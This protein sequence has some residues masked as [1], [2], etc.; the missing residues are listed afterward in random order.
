VSIFIICGVT[1]IIDAVVGLLNSALYAFENM[2]YDAIGQ[3]VRGSLLVAICLP[4]ICCKTPFIHILWISAGISSLKVLICWYGLRKKTRPLPDQRKNLSIAMSFSIFKD[5]FAFA[6]LSIVSV[7]YTNLIILLLRF[8]LKDDTS[9]GYFA[10]AQRIYLFAL[11]IPAMFYQAIYPVLSRKFVEVPDSFADIFEKLYRYLLAIAF[12]VAVGMAILAPF[13]IHLI[14]GPRFAPSVP[15]LRI[16]SLGLLNGPGFVMGAALSAMNKQGLNAVIFGITVIFLGAFSYFTIPTLGIEGAC[17]AMVVSN[18]VGLL[19]Y[20]ILLFKFLETPYP[21]KWLLK[22]SVATVAMGLCVIGTSY[23]VPGRIVS[24]SGSIIS[25]GAV[26]LA[27]LVIVRSFSPRDAYLVSS[28]LPISA[29][30]RNRIQRALYR[31]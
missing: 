11:I 19:V 12:P 1:T 20:S 10:A 30:N 14:Y 27:C 28:F 6:V 4:L 25:G 9:V 15:S 17:W 22:V 18:M 21:W 29:L 26:Y 23:Y 7:V 13:L 16:L 3:V 31:I 5:S 2:V 8:I 24:L